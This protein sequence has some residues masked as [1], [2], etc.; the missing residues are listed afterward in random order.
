M[1]DASNPSGDVEPA[2]IDE[3]FTARFAE[4]LTPAMVWGVVDRGELVHTGALGSV[5]TDADRPPGADSVFRI[6]SMS[7]SFTAAAV[8]LLRDRG[9][10]R[11]DDPVVEYVPELAWLPDDPPVTVRSL[12]TMGAGLLTDDPWGDRQESLPDDEFAAFLAGG[13]TVGRVP[14][15]GFEYSNL[16]YAVLGRVVA[17]AAGE[18]DHRRFVERELLAPLGMTASR[19]HHDEVGAA[20]VAGHVKRS[21]GWERLDP[22][23]PGAFSAMG[24]LHSSVADLARW[25]RGFVTA[26]ADPVGDDHP[27]RA[28]SR[29]EMQQL[30]R[31]VSADASLGEAGLSGLT[32]GYGYGLFVYHD[33]QLGQ[34]VGHSG[35]YPGYGSRMVWHPATGLGVITLSNGTYAGAYTQAD[36]ALR[37]LVRPRTRT[38][39]PV[40]PA[41]Y[42]WVDAVTRRLTAFDP[43]GDAPWVDP[44]TM[45]PNVALDQPDDERRAALARARQRVGAPLPRD[46]AS[47]AARPPDVYSRAMAHAAWVVPAER[48]RYDIEI[49][50]TPEPR[51]RLQTISVSAVPVADDT[52]LG[53]VR[54]ALAD[55]PAAARVRA[56]GPPELVE[57]PVSVNDRVTEFLVSAGGAWWKASVTTGDAPVTFELHPA[58]AYPRLAWLARQLRALAR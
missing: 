43:A 39:R 18:H 4:G 1:Q 58:A 37:R 50:L 38:P 23:P 41:T 3:L 22:T 54:S 13:V 57:H 2:T 10:L 53:R 20:L 45:S 30:Q 5:A 27:L 48:G 42:D 55:E 21:T 29:R 51:P 28:S 56:L 46:G 32:A 26:F 36:D 40:Y 12:L 34:F 44:E 17:A 33:S 35:G 15:L 47:G 6:A 16:G 8:L 25:V 11:L 24:G 52:T 14:G 9:A 31:F 19:Y 49:L 7:K